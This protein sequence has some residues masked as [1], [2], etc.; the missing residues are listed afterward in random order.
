MG[1][2]E[3]LN[4]CLVRCQ[5]LARES[6][7]SGN[8]TPDQAAKAEKIMQDCLGRCAADYEKQLPKLKSET[9]KRLKTVR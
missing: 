6:L 2:Q 4:R 1:F 3:R 8:P 9:L 7:P 5:D